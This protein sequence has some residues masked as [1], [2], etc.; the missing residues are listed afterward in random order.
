MSFTHSFFY[1]KKIIKNIQMKKIISSVIIVF[2]TL[3][4]YAQPIEPEAMIF[5]STRGGGVANEFDFKQVSKE[6][7]VHKFEIKN[8]G[9]TTLYIT[10]I[11]IPERIGVAV[12][13]KTVKKG[14]TAVFIVSVDPTVANKGAFKEDIII[15]TKQNEPG[16]KTTKVYTFTVK[17]VVK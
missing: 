10:D 3:A 2:L 9:N 12:I 15:S 5:G 14:E 1:G 17:G 6:V 13:S 7:A 16:V 8:E 4:T 11:Q